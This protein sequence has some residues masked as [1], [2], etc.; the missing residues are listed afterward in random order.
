MWDARSTPTRPVLLTKDG[1]PHGYNSRF[2]QQAVLRGYNVLD[3]GRT[4][5]YSCGGACTSISWCPNRVSSAQFYVARSTSMCLKTAC[6]SYRV[7]GLLIFCRLSAIDCSYMSQRP[8]AID[9]NPDFTACNT[10][11]GSHTHN[12][13]PDSRRSQRSRRRQFMSEGT[14]LRIGEMFK[15]FFNLIH[16]PPDPAMRITADYRGEYS[17]ELVRSKP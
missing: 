8:V 10:A 5:H 7:S 17:L 13:S 12:W 16:I 2:K 14:T 11:S 3:E 15:Q 6:Y 1:S 9:L 4:M